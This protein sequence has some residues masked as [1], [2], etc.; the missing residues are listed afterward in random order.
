MF[1]IAE[2][3]FLFYSKV[4]YLLV[5]MPICKPGICTYYIKQKTPLSRRVFCYPHYVSIIIRHKHKSL[6]EFLSLYLVKIKNISEFDTATL[7][8]YAINAE[9]SEE[10]ANIINFINQA[11]ELLVRFLLGLWIGYIY[12]NVFHNPRSTF[13]YHYFSYFYYKVKV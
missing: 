2:E 1:Y 6:F 7:I 12:F 10:W 11:C 8:M 9:V 13:L 4:L 3:E 5:F